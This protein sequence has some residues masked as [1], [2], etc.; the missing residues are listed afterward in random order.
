MAKVSFQISDVQHKEWFIVALL[1]HIQTPLMQK[2]LVSQT[3][4]LEIAMNLET[5]L[6]GD[7]NSGMIQIQS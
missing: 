7:T 5:S 2:K 4:A 1:P 6:V 3:E